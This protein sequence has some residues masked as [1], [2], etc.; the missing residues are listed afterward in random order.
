MKYLMAVEFQMESKAAK[1]SCIFDTAIEGQR[2]STP[3]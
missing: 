2:C 1:H 3:K